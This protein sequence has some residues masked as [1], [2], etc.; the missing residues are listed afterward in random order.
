MRRLLLAL[1][2]L[3]TAGSHPA[4]AQAPDKEQDKAAFAFFENKIRPVL[5]KECY[6]CHSANTR[7]GIGGT[8]GPKGGLALDTRDGLLKGG[9]SGKSIV[10]GKPTESLL[11]NALHGDG[12]STMPPK[13]KLSEAVIADFEK[14][15]KM[16]APDPRTEAATAVAVAGIDIEKGKQF[17]SFQ[18]V[19]ASAV[20]TIRNPQLTIRN[21][22]DPFIFAP[23]EAKGLKP[24]PDADP[25]TL[26]RR[27][28]IDLI[29]LPPSPE[30]VEAFV[31]DP[32]PAAYTAVVDR[33]LASPR[34]GE[35]WG[36]HWLD[37]ARYAD[38]NGRDENL[39]FHEAYLYRDY[40]IQAF[41]SDKPFNRFIVEQLAGDLLK[42]ETQTERDELLKAT[43]FL[44]VGPK[45]LAER[46]KPKLR[47]DV[48][49][50]QIDTIGK[51]FLGLTLGCARCHDH[52]FDPVPT[53]DYYS[54]AGILMSTR[55]VNG[56]KLGNA[57]V[58]GWILRPLGLPEPE[59]VIAARTL[60][61]ARLKKLQTE[62]KSVK[63]LL[64]VA[65]DKAAMRNPG[66][67]L[68]IT[69][70][71]KDAKLVGVWKA[72]VFTKPYVGEGYIHDDK[73]GKGQKSATFTPKLP[74]A[75]E[76]EVLI[77]YTANAGRDKNVPV[78][79][80]C[81]DG[82]KTVIVDQVKPPEI[83]GL[84]HSLGKFKFKAGS[85]GSVT[86]SNKGT[87]NHVIVDAVRF[88]PVGE[89][90]KLPEMMGMGVAADVKAAVTENLAKLKALEAAELALK[91]DAPP[92][93]KMV[94]AVQDEATIED[95]KINIRGNPAQLGA[96]VPRGFLQVASVGPKPTLPAN[97]SGRLQLAEWIASDTN[98]LTARVAVNR[99]WM[100]LFGSGL[101]RT[102]DNFGIQGE[103]PSHPELLDYLALQFT[104]NGWSHKKLIREMV[105]S[106]A[107]QLSVNADE[108]LLKADVE[109]RLFGRAN[110][111]RVEA[112]VIR[113]TILMV[114]GKLDLNGGGPV[115]SHLPEKAIE[116]DSKGGFN[117]DPLTKRAVYL[118]VLR[119]DLP[120]LFEVFDFADPDVANGHRD[121]T[122]VSTQAL[123]LMNSTF[124]NT[125]A[126]LAA[127]SLLAESTDDAKRLEL[128][129]RRALG[130][131]PTKAEAATSMKFLVD[132]QK[133]I[134]M[135]PTGQKPKNP[136]LAAWSAVCLSVFGCSEFRFVE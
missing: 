77:S 59:K 27:L 104:K 12:V 105:L 100:H 106:H 79:I 98:P 99:V 39:T 69:V 133:T 72:S 91:N 11:I 95:A 63:A 48:V 132:Y 30:D 64:A 101:V 36:R 70:D 103:K 82:E 38:S 25:Q 29:G 20:P 40:V 35:R 125:H 129:F 126:R 52:K 121:A 18:P 131:A 3:T 16:G 97:E 2:V 118:P 74:K 71:D 108:S 85:A 9:D 17:W 135:L 75:G 24:A 92:P 88:V 26:I 109:N 28:Y 76:Y 107:Y 127:E 13:G 112:E 41:N 117:S 86:I 32:S 115:V 83:D 116:N 84:F 89:L 55:T 114:S 62:I 53:A 43:G 51:S 123:Y 37:L 111:R 80:N 119:N 78:T 47:M 6:S 134:E 136:E 4:F 73:T 60:Y 124:T 5:V 87:E 130:R 45:I 14:W 110:R 128:L 93:A 50:E 1:A 61:N 31:K 33:L 67:L 49:D 66:T 113:D 42:A 81:D 90:A 102:V 96:Q 19:R 7:S 8:R 10:S 54:M 65:Q 15:V 57:L 44:V 68:G 58:S 120:T 46:D 94:M 122:T 34:F 21:G 23:L 56:I 22:I